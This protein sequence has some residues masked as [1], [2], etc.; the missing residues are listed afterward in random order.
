V[1]RILK[2][3]HLRTLFTVCK[4]SKNTKFN[5]HDVNDLI[6][7]LFAGYDNT[8]VIQVGSPWDI[9]KIGTT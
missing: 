9:T 5:E 6:C 7:S 2:P 8:N 1:V 3:K 4:Y